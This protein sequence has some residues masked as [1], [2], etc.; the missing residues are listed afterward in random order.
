VEKVRSISDKFLIAVEGAN[1]TTLKVEGLVGMDF[2]GMQLAEVVEHYAQD[3]RDVILELDSVGGYISDAFT[4][5]DQVR[6]KGLRV[7]VDGY[8]T[9]ASAATIMMAAAGKKRSRLS[10]NSEYLI[11]NASG[12]DASTLDR[13]NKKMAAIYAELTG[14]TA[15]EIL[16][17]MKQDKPMSAQDAKR[18]GFVG[19][20]IELQRL[21]AIKTQ[22]M[23]DE[24]IKVKQLFAIDRNKALSALVTGEV[25]LEFDASKDLTQKIGE[26]TEELKAK[27]TELDELKAEVELKDEAVKAK[28]D[29][30]TALKDAEAKHL[31]D[32]KTVTSDVEKLKAQITT[33]KTAPVDPKVK[34]TAS[35]P[36]TDTDDEPVFKKQTAEQRAKAFADASNEIIK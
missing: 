26:L 13:T 33:L 14:K 7:H 25:E 32:L 11:H 30:V 17:L 31:E 15:A 4:F 2:S 21:A 29:A 16:T 10:P 1:A 8:G 35:A 6:A 28:D 27:S 34:A 24:T 22:T 5:Y 36:T 19:S 9:V 20:V 23:E 12:G 18:M 3:N